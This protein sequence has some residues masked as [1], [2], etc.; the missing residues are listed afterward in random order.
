VIRS[1]RVARLVVAVSTT[2]AVGVAGSLA[3]ASA[4]DAKPKPKP[5][6]AVSGRAELPKGGVESPG[7]A[8]ITETGSTLLYPLWNIWTP[9]YTAKYP[10]VSITTAGTGS[11]TGIA[12]AANGT[13]DI[14]SSDAYLSPAQNQEE[15]TLENIPL[16][17]SVQVIAYNLPGITAHLRLSGKVLRHLPRAHHLVEQFG[18]RL[19]QSWGEAPLDPDRR[20]ASFRRKR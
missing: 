10:S 8:T 16:A 12:D 17:I 14:G 2:F 3:I 15:P 1:R 20:P 7:S 4:A 11:G 19:G 13:V 18:H 5:K 9:A 6:S